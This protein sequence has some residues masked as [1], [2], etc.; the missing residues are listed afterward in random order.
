MNQRT[1]NILEYI[2]RCQVEEGFTPTVREIAAAVD[3]SSPSTVHTHLLNLEKAGYL[4]RLQDQ[5]RRLEVTEA[6][7]QYLGIQPDLQ[8]IPMLGTVTA[9]MPITAFEEF[10]D[11]F[12][13][14]PQLQHEESP[15]FMLNIRGESMINIGICDDDWVIVRKQEN[16]NNGDI[17]IAMTAEDEATCK[18]F[19]KEDHY[20]R[21]HPENDTMDDILLEEV[22]ILGKVVGLYRDF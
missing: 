21:L 18:R 16:A 4:N 8:Q 15:L 7:K 22:Q 9:G 6:G 14:P 19:F 11:F 12:P 2:Y 20:F 17:V 1:F 5:S 13:I 3:L 10:T